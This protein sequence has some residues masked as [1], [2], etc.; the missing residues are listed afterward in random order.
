M[1]AHFISEGLCAGRACLIEEGDFCSCCKAAEVG[2]V[3]L[4]SCLSSQATLEVAWFM[5]L[6]F[7][8]LCAMAMRTTAFGFPLT[9]RWAPM[10]P[11]CFA[12]FTR[13]YDANTEEA[14]PCIYSYS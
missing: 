11:I 9:C 6:S 3:L 4:L 12:G 5:S 8:C 1:G 13:Q 2:A 14:I 7:W 10:L